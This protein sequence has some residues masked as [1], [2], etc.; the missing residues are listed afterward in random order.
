LLRYLRGGEAFFSS[1]QERLEK[2]G[3]RMVAEIV[4]RKSIAT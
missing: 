1:Q 2:G 4:Y 3:T